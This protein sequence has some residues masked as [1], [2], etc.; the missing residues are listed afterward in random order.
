MKTYIYSER[1]FSVFCNAVAMC[2]EWG[3]QKWFSADGTKFA[4]MNHYGSVFCS[5]SG[6]PRTW[7][8]PLNYFD[9]LE[10]LNPKRF[11]ER[12]YEIT[13]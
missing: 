2:L 13:D 11:R 6:E 4:V 9:D 8:I 5:A 7:R 12:P 1:E 3:G 10:K